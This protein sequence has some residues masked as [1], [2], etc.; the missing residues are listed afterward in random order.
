M[1]LELL[2]GS[3]SREDARFWS[4]IGAGTRTSAGVNVNE[5]T[6]LYFSAYFCA[7]AIISGDE[8]TLPLHAYRR[9]SDDQRQR[10][11]GHWVEEALNIEPNQDG[12][13]DAI[14]FRETLTI[15]ALGWGNG[16]AEIERAG[17]R[18]FALHIL[19]PSRV[20]VVQTKSGQLAYE[21]KNANGTPDLVPP[22]RIFHLRGPGGDGLT[23][24]SIARLAKETIGLALAAEQYGS[25]WFGNGARPGGVLKHPHRLS[26]TAADRI[27]ESW[28]NL[29]AGPEHA[30]EIAVLE[31]GMEFQ[32]LGIPPEDSQFLI[33]RLFQIREIARWFKIPS[34]FLGD[35]E[36]ESYASAEMLELFYLNRC[37]RYWL[38]RWERAIQRSLLLRSERGKIYVEHQTEALL[39]ADL[40][41]RYEAYRVAREGGWMSANDV[42]RRENM[43][44]IGPQGDLYLVPKNF[45]SAEHLLEHGDWDTGEE[46]NGASSVKPPE[47]DGELAAHS[48]AL[49][50]GLAP[51]GAEGDG[52]PHEGAPATAAQKTQ[53]PEAVVAAH[54]ALLTDA[55]GRM[56]RKEV[57]NVKQAAK[58][59]GEFLAW[60]DGYYPHHEKLLAEALTP[61]LAAWFAVLGKEEPGGWAK[62]TAA[63]HCNDSR[64]RLL[65]A[66][67]V[68]PAAFP[69]AVEACVAGWEQ[70]AQETAAQLIRTEGR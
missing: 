63:E 23:G 22:E 58:K 65:E 28:K 62:V 60:M 11:S 21:V 55:L 16:Y 56:V 70:R 39:K 19:H 6:A 41:A 14:S 50:P 59:P 35:P 13:T 26:K 10:E 53:P 1:L 7:M 61:P 67:G 43:N 69:A 47:G 3:S 34:R 38:V 20:K 37:L 51:E 27:R 2:F 68:T 42:L 54:R 9:V 29:H 5:T 25:G 44:P 17:A 52:T 45:G 49:Q 48:L 12:I 30:H 46:E 64:G 57:A 32:A 18:P 15:H 33:T 4:E 31:E 40:K 36:G 66:A 8:A 24:W